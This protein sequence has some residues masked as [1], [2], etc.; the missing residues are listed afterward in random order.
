[1]RRRRRRRRRR[2]KKASRPLT[3]S[4]RLERSHTA[5]RTIHRCSSV[6]TTINKF[7]NFNGR[8]HSGWRIGKGG[9]GRREGRREGM[10]VEN[11]KDCCLVAALLP[12]WPF[13]GGCHCEIELGG[14]KKK[15]RKLS[16][17][18]RSSAGRKKE[19]KFGFEIRLRNRRPSSRPMIPPNYPDECVR[20]KSR[21]PARTRNGRTCGTG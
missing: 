18:G 13:Y 20:D 15:R 10:G 12:L 5:G 6:S 4:L 21:N 8:Y 7:R 9:G 2:R 11:E 17:G 16:G 3:S 19:K 14:R 1:M